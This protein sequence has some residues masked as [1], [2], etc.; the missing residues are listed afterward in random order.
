[1]AFHRKSTFNLDMQNPIFNKSL[2]L[3]TNL[4]IMMT[5]DDY[6]NER[7]RGM[8]LRSEILLK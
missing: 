3:D 7:E 8:K 4:K 6:R 2:E 5:L 1:M